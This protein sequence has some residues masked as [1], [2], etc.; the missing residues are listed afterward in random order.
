MKTIVYPNIDTDTNETP[1]QV[2]TVKPCDHDMCHHCVTAILTVTPPLTL[3]RPSLM[4]VFSWNSLHVD[5]A[6]TT[7]FS[8]A[9]G[10]GDV[11]Q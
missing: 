1:T 10:P 9:R 5:I 4:R 2:F 6:S 7:L 11:E 8:L 3:L